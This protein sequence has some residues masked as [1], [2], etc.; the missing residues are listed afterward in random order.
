MGIDFYLM[1]VGLLISGCLMLTVLFI[2]KKYFGED[3]D[4]E[5]TT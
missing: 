1:L 4:D 2:L 3:K 5:K